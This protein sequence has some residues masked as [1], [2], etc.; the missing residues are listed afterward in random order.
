MII[1]KILKNLIV[2]ISKKNESSFYIV[3]NH[4]SIL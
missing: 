4:I 1:K 2:I 3:T